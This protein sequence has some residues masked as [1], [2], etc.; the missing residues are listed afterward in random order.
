MEMIIQ[1]EIQIVPIRDPHTR[2]E[3]IAI[4]TSHMPIMAAGE[5]QCATRKQSLG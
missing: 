4:S 3:L 5:L 2:F 1:R